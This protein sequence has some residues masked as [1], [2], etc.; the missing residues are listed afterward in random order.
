MTQR[1]EQSILWLGGWGQFHGTEDTSS[2]S[3][4]NRC[5]QVDKDQEGIPE[6]EKYIKT[7]V[8]KKVLYLQSTATF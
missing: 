8:Y 3:V 7:S 1:R 5:H 6:R 4:T 2:S